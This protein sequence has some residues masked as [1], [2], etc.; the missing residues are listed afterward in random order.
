MKHNLEISVNS[1]L[2]NLIF[3]PWKFSL[4]EVLC[5]HTPELLLIPVSLMFFNI[6]DTGIAVGTNLS[7]ISLLPNEVIAIND[8]NKTIFI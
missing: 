7:V 6:L 3:P 2:S 1:L 4:S 8:T 5:F